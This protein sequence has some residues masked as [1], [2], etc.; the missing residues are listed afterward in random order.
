M[1]KRVGIEQLSLSPRRPDRKR[2]PVSGPLLSLVRTFGPVLPVVVRERAPRQYEILAN[3][4]T[5][6]AAQQLGF[7]EVS[8]VVRETVSDEQADALLR[9]QRPENPIAVARRYAETLDA[10]PDGR[11]YGAITALARTEGCSR[12]HVAHRL[13]LLALPDLVQH[14]VSEGLLNLGQ[15]KAIAGV[16]PA[17]RQMQLATEAIRQ[18]WSVRQTERAVRDGV[19]SVGQGGA[20]TTAQGRQ[21][22]RVERRL[23]ELLG[24]PVVLDVN[25]GHL[26]IDYR[27]D[28]GVLNGILEQLGYRAD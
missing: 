3:A 23:G 18:R 22:Q 8:I 5:W 13:R 15:A 24:S 26:I 21:T 20:R 12:S 11:S 7:H 17:E 14:A 19:A 1:E 16:A 6:L 27:R 10:S 2:P 25:A 28:L 4:E 9:L